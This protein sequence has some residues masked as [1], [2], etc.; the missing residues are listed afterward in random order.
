M[1]FSLGEKSKTLSKKKKIEFKNQLYVALVNSEGEK[2]SLFPN[3][4]LCVEEKGE[5]S[6]VK[7][8]CLRAYDTSNSGK[9]KR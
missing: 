6:G 8:G 3:H 4:S 9:V 5:E 2:T 7:S 1:H